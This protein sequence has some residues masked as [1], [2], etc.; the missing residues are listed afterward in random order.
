MEFPLFCKRWFKNDAPLVKEKGRRLN[1]NNQDN[2]SRLRINNLNPLDTGYYRCEA[3]NK[4]GRVESTS[5]L[6][7]NG[8]P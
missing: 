7:V 2:L 1:V 5:L 3:T 8:N 6:K 4:A